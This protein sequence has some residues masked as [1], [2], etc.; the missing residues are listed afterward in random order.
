MRKTLP[1]TPRCT[2][3]SDRQNEEDQN[4]YPP[5]FS[6]HTWTKS[7]PFCHRVN[8]IKPSGSI[9]RN[10]RLQL[11]RRLRKINE[12]REKGLKVKI[13]DEH[14][15]VVKDLLSGK[16]HE[17]RSKL[18]T[19]SKNKSENK[20]QPPT[21]KKLLPR[22]YRPFLQKCCALNPDEQ[23]DI[24]KKKWKN[25]NCNETLINEDAERINYYLNEGIADDAFEPY[26][27]QG[28][29]K[30]KKNRVDQNLLAKHSFIAAKLDNEI[31][32]NYSMA[33]RRIILDYILMDPAELKR[34]KITKYHL[35]DFPKM[36][37]RGPVPWH[38]MTA[39][40]SEQLRHKL[41]IFKEPILLLNKIWKK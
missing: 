28:L 39:I 2:V 40:K 24:L 38:H 26:P 35:P 41:Y 12:A 25:I 17:E 15:H 7:V 8:Q 11:E 6:L 23:L 5:L 30:L 20:K 13:L 33:S 19:K 32:Q 37:I 36:V 34:L 4:D 22:R 18:L 21:K 29:E 1:N 3:N 10:Y 16:Y 9:G 31:C 27:K 14:K